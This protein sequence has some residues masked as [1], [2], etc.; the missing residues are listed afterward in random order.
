MQ[1]LSD[2]GSADAGKFIFNFFFNLMI[3]RCNVAQYI[4]TSFRF[5]SWVNK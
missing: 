5:S 3:R 4:E 1:W 2:S